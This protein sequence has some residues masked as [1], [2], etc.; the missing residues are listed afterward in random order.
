MLY[1]SYVFAFKAFRQLS[2]CISHESGESKAYECSHVPDSSCPCLLF[3][4]SRGKRAKQARE[5]PAAQVDRVDPVD[6]QAKLEDSRTAGPSRASANTPAH[7]STTSD[8]LSF[9]FNVVAACY[10][11]VPAVTSHKV[12]LLKRG[13]NAPMKDLKLQQ[14]GDL[15]QK[16]K[17]FAVLLLNMPGR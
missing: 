5:A 17:P 7:H 10:R 12:A 6:L 8:V 11:K 4:L 9:P 3:L 2:I 14:V 16:A 15:I 1:A 13:S